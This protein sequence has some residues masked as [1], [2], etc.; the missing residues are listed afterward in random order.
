LQLNEFSDCYALYIDVPDLTTYGNIAVYPALFG[1]HFG[2]G[3][4]GVGWDSGGT[5][6]VT[7]FRLNLT[8]SLYTTNGTSFSL[9]GN[10][11]WTIGCTAAD[12]RPTQL[13]AAE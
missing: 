5:K 2:G 6:Y 9:V 11:T 3:V 4:I 12:G 10:A 13:S 7:I 1:G 8:E